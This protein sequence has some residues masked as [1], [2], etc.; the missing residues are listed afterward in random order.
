MSEVPHCPEC[1]R[2]DT[3][4]VRKGPRY[5][6][7]C[8]NCNRVIEADD[9]EDKVFFERVKRSMFKNPRKVEDQVVHEYSEKCQ[10]EWCERGRPGI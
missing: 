4:E 2:A 7:Y 6:Y 3:V 9:I 1:R 5:E 8:S 10:C